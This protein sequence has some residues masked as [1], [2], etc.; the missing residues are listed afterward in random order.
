MSKIYILY[1]WCGDSYDGDWKVHGVYDT[2]LLAL[3]IMSGLDK[4]E[5]STA[6]EEHE[7]I[8]RA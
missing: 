4:D 8:T 6:I 3:E 2:W 7:V 5:A 1:V